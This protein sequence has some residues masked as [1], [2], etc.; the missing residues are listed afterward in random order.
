LVIRQTIVTATA[1]TRRGSTGKECR[2]GRPSVVCKSG[3][4]GKGN[5]IIT[6]TISPIRVF[7]AGALHQEGSYLWTYITAFLPVYSCNLKSSM[8]SYACHYCRKAET[9]GVRFY[10]S[11]WECC[12]IIKLN[13]GRAGYLFASLK[14]GGQYCCLPILMQMASVLNVTGRFVLLCRIM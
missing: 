14:T 2:D 13:S 11:I 8:V 1:L 4:T 12:I 5:G 7:Q 6:G 9:K 10:D 3:I